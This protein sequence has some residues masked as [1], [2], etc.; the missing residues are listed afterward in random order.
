MPSKFWVNGAPVGRGISANPT[1]LQIAKTSTRTALDA[2]F[3]R[4]LR[5]DV[6]RRKE[7]ELVSEMDAFGMDHPCAS[8]FTFGVFSGSWIN[9]LG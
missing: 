1:R 8:K 2:N 3:P 4:S 9:Y 7:T 6:G 5:R